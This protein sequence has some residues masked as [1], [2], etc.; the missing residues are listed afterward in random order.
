METNLVVSA[1]GKDRPGLV[2]ELAHA[3]ADCGCRIGESRMA[4][5]G[6]EFAAI[7]L[8]RGNWNA[9]A[10]LEQTLP[11]LSERLVMRI[12]GQRT[13]TRID[14]GDLVPYGIEVVAIARPGIVHDVANFFSRRDINIED[15]YSSNYPAPH[16]GAL[17]FSLHLTV[18]IPSDVSIAAVR[19]EFMDFCDELNLD[20]MMA[21]VK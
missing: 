14:T 11:R 21:P 17:M 20:A 8:V 19:G 4:V 16:T 10:K 2:D 13:E 12:H 15:V 7:M 18:G 5:L 9:I 6:N 1:T 3:V